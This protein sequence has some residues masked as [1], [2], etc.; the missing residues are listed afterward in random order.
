MGWRKS[1]GWPLLIA[2]VVAVFF[3]FLMMMIKQFKRCP[4]NRVL[5]IYGKVGRGEHARSAS[6][7]APRSSCR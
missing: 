5:V 4:S 1:P 2:A 7:A 3:I 6:T